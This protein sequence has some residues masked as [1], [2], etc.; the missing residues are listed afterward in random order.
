MN[1]VDHLCDFDTCFIIVADHLET[2]Q[3]FFHQRGHQAAHCATRRSN[4]LQQE[5]EIGFCI[6]RP[7]QCGELALNA[8]KPSGNALIAS[9]KY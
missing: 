2:A 5:C 1:D 6:Q 9:F 4:S 8:P 3:P 7:L